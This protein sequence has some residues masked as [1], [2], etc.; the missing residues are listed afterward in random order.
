MYKSKILFHFNHIVK[1]F[2][3]VI[4]VIKKLKSFYVIQIM[5]TITLIQS[6]TS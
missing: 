1:V 6:V 3:N 4:Q 2:I 5:I